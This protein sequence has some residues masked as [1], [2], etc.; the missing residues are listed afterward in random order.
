MPLTA[1]M[2][3]S[4]EAAG[5]GSAPNGAMPV[6]GTPYIRVV[7]LRRVFC[8]SDG[9]TRVAVEG[10]NLEMSA[11]RITALLGHNG[12]GKTTSIHMLTGRSG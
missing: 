6:P 2:G 5:A 11:G 4:N 10:L 3:D 7:G 9:D 1:A 8:S 12:A